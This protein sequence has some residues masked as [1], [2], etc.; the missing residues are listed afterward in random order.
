MT[1]QGNERTYRTIAVT[2]GKGGV[3]K[4]NLTM[5]L[6]VLMA[7]H[8]RRILV[9]DADLGLANLD[10]ILGLKSP[11]QLHHVIRGEK[12]ILEIVAEGPGG[13]RI[14]TGGSG[15]LELL[16][17]TEAQRETF[18]GEFWKLG[19]VAD[20]VLF[21]TGA[22]LS[23]NVLAFLLAADEVVVVATPEP[24]SITDAYATIK[25]IAQKNRHASL[26]LIVNMVEAPEEALNVAE[27]LIQVCQQFLNIKIEYIGY[28]PRDKNV[29]QAIRSQQAFTIAFPQT[30]ASRHLGSV[31]AQLLRSIGEEDEDSKFI[32]KIRRFFGN[33]A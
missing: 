11:Y 15:I 2:S 23:S 6:G 7:Q 30:P 29:L 16:E 13:T 10:V 8:G 3:G 26:K 17:L 5:N 27:K 24:A 18:I 22:G 21:D 25:V 19:S 12:D 4:T 14:I 28:V 1:I 33:A 9:L 32:G 20:I 31:A